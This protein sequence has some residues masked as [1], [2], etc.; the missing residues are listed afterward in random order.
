M[1]YMQSI[2]YIYIQMNEWYTRNAYFHQTG[3]FAG[4]VASSAVNILS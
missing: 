4:C 1:Q 2:L 3:K